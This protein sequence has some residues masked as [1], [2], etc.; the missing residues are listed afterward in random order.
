MPQQIVE[1]TTPTLHDLSQQIHHRSYTSTLAVRR[2]MPGL[3]LSCRRRIGHTQNRVPTPHSW[4]C[5]DRSRAAPPAVSRQLAMLQKKVAT[6]A[7][8]LLRNTKRKNLLVNCKW[9]QLVF[10]HKGMI[11]E[12]SNLKWNH[13]SD[14]ETIID[15]HCEEPRIR[16]EDARPRML[17]R[18]AEFH[19]L[20]SKCFKLRNQPH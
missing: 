13:I 11:G 6:S 7:G 15:S 12:S 3:W 10:P 18:V 16:G 8:S 14:H 1:C 4:F 20:S 9:S 5:L 2:T 17:V 19:I